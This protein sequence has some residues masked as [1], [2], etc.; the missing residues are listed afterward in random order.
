[1]MVS[2]L[3]GGGTSYLVRLLAEKEPGV[4]L[5]SD[6]LEVHQEMMHRVAKK[7]GTSRSLHVG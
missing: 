3:P 2:G 1:M 7:I 6:D 4:M 5:R